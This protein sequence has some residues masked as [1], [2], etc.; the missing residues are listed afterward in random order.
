[1]KKNRIIML[2]VGALLLVTVAAPG[3]HLPRGVAPAEGGLFI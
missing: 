2:A 3:F 1:M